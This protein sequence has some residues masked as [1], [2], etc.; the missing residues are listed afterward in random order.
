LASNAAGDWLP[1]P[2]LACLEHG[3]GQ[4]A[5]SCD[6]LRVPNA[7]GGR[8]N[9]G[10]GIDA[11]VTIADSGALHP[12][13]FLIASPEYAHGV[14][15]VIQN[16]RD[17][18]VSFD[19]SVRKPVARVHIS[20]RVHHSHDSLAEILHA[21]SMNLVADASVSV[22]LPGYCRTEHEMLRLPEVQGAI[23]RIFA[24]LDADS[25]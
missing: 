19:G 24:A 12:D 10:I 1:S 7:Q 22:P 6:C 23:N 20:P 3:S 16:T 21:M 9:R 13:A 8:I 11:D 4:G 15:G 25:R 18:L 2:R 5:G 14:S 17:W